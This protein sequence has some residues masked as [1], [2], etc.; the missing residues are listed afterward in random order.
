MIL[1][2]IVMRTTAPR[3]ATDNITRLE[4]TCSW[5]GMAWLI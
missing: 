2:S 1:M 4:H 5:N 3:T